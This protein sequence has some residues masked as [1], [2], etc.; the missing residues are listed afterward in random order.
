MHRAVFLVLLFHFYLSLIYI[1]KEPCHK[2]VNSTLFSHFLHLTQLLLF[3]S[4]EFFLSSIPGLNANS[5][6]L[7]IKFIVPKVIS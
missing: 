2:N 6:D 1:P 4:A 7:L 5:N 3:L